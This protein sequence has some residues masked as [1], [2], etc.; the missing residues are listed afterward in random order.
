MLKIM[1]KLTRKLGTVK[2]KEFKER[3]DEICDQYQTKAKEEG[4]NGDLLFKK[5]KGNMVIFV[6]IET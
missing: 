5:E 3:F 4:Y 2:L 1:D 6:T